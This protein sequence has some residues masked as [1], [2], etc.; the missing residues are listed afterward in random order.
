MVRTPLKL[1]NVMIGTWPAQNIPTVHFYTCHIST[2]SL[3]S[4]AHG[5]TCSLYIS[6]YVAIFL[7][8]VVNSMLSVYS[9]YWYV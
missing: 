6:W 7:T 2:D 5:L 3:N 8:V 9:T 1:S 4:A